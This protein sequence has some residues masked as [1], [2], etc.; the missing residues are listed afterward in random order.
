MSIKSIQG[1]THPL[2]GM[3]LLLSGKEALAAQA[4]Y[5]MPEGATEISQQIYHLHMLSLWICVIIGIGVFGAMLYSIVMFRKSKGAQPAHFHENTFIEILWTTVPF[6]ILISMAIPA[7]GT[8]I[9][10]ADVSKADMTVKITGYQWKW[11]YD[12]LGQGVS[13]FSTLGRESN[14]ARQLGSNIDPASV[15]NYLLDV[16]HPLVLPVGVKVRLVITSNDVIHSWW[17]PEFANKTDAL[18][19]FVNETWLKID[20]PGIY[21]GQCAELCGRDHAFMPIVVVA[22]P[23]A[24]FDAWLAEQKK[25]APAAGTAAA[26]PATPALAAPPTS[27]Q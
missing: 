12:Y 5:N 9:R 18:P 16:D 20:K 2:M 6:L 8:L 21:R 27:A 23:K 1:L 26:A 10:M 15:D 24:E 4:R 19:G 13:F 22:K 17:V 7:A 11:H 14:L 25:S 3:A